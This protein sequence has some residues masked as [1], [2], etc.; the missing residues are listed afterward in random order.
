[1]LESYPGAEPM[2]QGIDEGSYVGV[3]VP[4]AFCSPVDLQPL[5]QLEKELLTYFRNHF[6]TIKVPIYVPLFILFN[7]TRK[8]L[9]YIRTQRQTQYAIETLIKKRYIERFIAYDKIFLTEVE[10]AADMDMNINQIMY[11][12]S[13]KKVITTNAF[14]NGHN[15]RVIE[16]LHQFDECRMYSPR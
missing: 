6:G 16:C 15:N 7:Y 14:V 3:K 11:N 12:P 2:L 5:N 13:T 1:M 10:L 9:A 8:R 4:F